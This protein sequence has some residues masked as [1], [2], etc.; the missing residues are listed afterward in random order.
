V[1]CCARTGASAA[2]AAAAAAARDAASGA[3]PH[4]AQPCQLP[5]SDAAQSPGHASLKRRLAAGAEGVC[6]LHS[7]HELSHKHKHTDTSANASLLPAA[8]VVCVVLVV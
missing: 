7:C 5:S 1:P 4:A 8:P 3:R 6:Q 2:G